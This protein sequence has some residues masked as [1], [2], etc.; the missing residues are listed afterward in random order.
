V[1]GRASKVAQMVLDT[2][3]PIY[4]AAG[5]GVLPEGIQTRS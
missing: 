1:L 5:R 3:M 2:G 4:D